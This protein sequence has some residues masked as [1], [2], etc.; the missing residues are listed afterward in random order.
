MLFRSL[1][2]LIAEFGDAKFDIS[3][4]GAILST[5]SA[6]E[7][8]QKRQDSLLQDQLADIKK[9]LS[10]ITAT[11]VSKD[12]DKEKMSQQI[13]ALQKQV[14][15]MQSLVDNKN[16]EI[17]ELKLK[18]KSAEDQTTSLRQ[19]LNNCSEEDNSCSL[20]IKEKAKEATSN[21]L[22]FCRLIDKHDLDKDLLIDLHNKMQKELL[23]MLKITD[24]TTSVHELIMQARDAVLLTDEACDYAHLIRKERNKIVHDNAYPKT[25]EARILMCLYAASL[26]WPHFPE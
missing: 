3:N 26:L 4:K 15:S 9:Q 12:D 11:P 6:K 21:D 18:T 24:E 10:Q 1:D 20:S 25:Y 2:Q 14:S 16:L 17:A 7:A 5:S 22:K 23:K 13:A 8:A 19:L